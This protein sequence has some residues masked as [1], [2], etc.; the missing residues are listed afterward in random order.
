MYPCDEEKDFI[1]RVVAVAGDTVEVRCSKLYVN[2]ELVVPELSPQECQYWDLDADKRWIEESCSLYSETVEGETYNTI[3]SA[4]RPQDD[5][6]R[7][8]NPLGSYSRMS[9]I[10]DFPTH[11]MPSCRDTEDRERRDRDVIDAATGQ[12]VELTPPD[13]VCAPRRHFVIPPE[14]LFVMGDNRDNSSDSRVWGPVPVK[15]VKG[16]A[17]FIWR[18][19]KGS[20]EWDRIGKLV[21]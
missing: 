5:D 10:H 20:T 13:K 11:S 2:G 17:L 18:S 7:R 1:K 3:F 6:E 9:D 8:S 19:T 14:H 15:N 12:I 21:H 4:A 16:K